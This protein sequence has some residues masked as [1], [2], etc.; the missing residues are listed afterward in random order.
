M[1]T[2]RELQLKKDIETVKKILPSHYKVTASSKPYNV[3]CV[4]KK[5][6]SDADEKTFDRIM[7]QFRKS[8][9]KRFQEVYHEVCTNH[10]DFTVYLKN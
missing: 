5:G 8:F 1:A 4:S 7:D 3:H 10:L 6:I 9:G 2:K